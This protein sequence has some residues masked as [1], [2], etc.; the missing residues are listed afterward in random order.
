MKEK[1]KILFMIINMN[2]GG[3]EKALLNMIAT[4]PKDKY[5]ISI[6]MLER[7][8]G[9]LENIPKHVHTRYLDNFSEIKPLINNPPL[10]S[11]LTLIKQKKYLEFIRFNTFYMLSKMCNN[12]SIF[13]KYLVR[14]LPQINY[15]YDTAIAYAGPM[16]FISYFILEKVTAAKKVQWIHFDVSKIGFNQRFAEKSY[17]KFDALYIVSKEARSKL[18]EQVPSLNDKLKVQHNTVSHQIVR[19]QSKNGVGFQDNFNGTRI[20]TVGRLSPEKG[21]DLS[22]KVLSRLVREGHHIKWYVL[23]EGKSREDYET[24]IKD[25]SVESNFI[26]LGADPNPYPY[27]NQCDIYVQPSR[28]EGYCITLLEAKA[29]N[30]PIVATRVNGVNEQLIHERT[31]LITEIAEEEIYESVR[32]LIINKDLRHKLSNNLLIENSKLET[33]E[34]II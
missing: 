21:H 1:E 19:Q 22:I 7:K 30:K 34:L 3:T 25:F 20:L 4:M 28:Y 15:K 24:L 18:L 11:S 16:D 2:I 31:G 17:K 26:L 13:L 5:D 32:K 6:L 33:E 10:Q 12:K 14:N 23:G 27:M 9:F 8:G 29:L